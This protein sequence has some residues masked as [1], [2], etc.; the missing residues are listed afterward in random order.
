MY[1]EIQVIIY[2]KSLV[3]IVFL[4]VWWIKL[5]W[6]QMFFFFRFRN[7]N[8]WKYFLIQK[9]VPFLSFS[10]NNYPPGFTVELKLVWLFL[11]KIIN[12]KLSKLCSF[13]A[14]THSLCCIAVGMYHKW[15]TAG[16]QR[17]VK[18][19][20]FFYPPGKCAIFL[21]R[22]SWVVDSFQI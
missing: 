11:F 16:P 12:K 1:G 10:K 21:T 14:K 3:E 7:I 8:T 15:T 17:R 5:H 18:I 20:Y 22:S 13:Y 2:H 19:E 4:N 9:L 6:S